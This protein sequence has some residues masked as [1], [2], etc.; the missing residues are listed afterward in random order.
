MNW[1]KIKEVASW[2]QYLHWAQ[3]NVDRWICPEDH[4]E[5]ESI[6]VA[7]QFFASMY[8]VIEGWEQLKLEDSEID[9]ILSQNEEGVDLLRRAR[10]SVYHFQKEMHGEKMLAFAN[11]LGRDDWIIRLY[12]EFV[13]FLGEYPKKVFPFNER[14]EEF[15][16]R[17]YDLLG[18]KP[19]YE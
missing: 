13:R 3:L 19:D 18:W 8:V 15:S 6:A 14:E 9:N 10:N 2:G 4:T 16:S 17:F 12:Y 1:N 7:Y 5:V 11:E